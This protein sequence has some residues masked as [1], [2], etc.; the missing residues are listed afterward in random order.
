MC[1]TLRRTGAV[2]LCSILSLFCLTFVTHNASAQSVACNDNVQ[3]SLDENCQ[4]DIT[5]D[6]I[7]EGNSPIDPADYTVTISGVMGTTITTP[8]SYSVTVTL[9]ATGNNCWG[10][11]V[12]EDK[13]APQMDPT[14][15]V[16]CACPPGNTDPAC[17]FLCTDLDGILNGTVA[18]PAPAPVENCTTVTSVSNDVV[19]DGAMCGEQIITRTTVYTD[20]AGNTSD[21]CIQEFRLVTIDVTTDITAPATPVQLEC[22]ASASMQSI[23]DYFEPTLGT[24]GAAAQAWPTINGSPITGQLCNIVVTKVD[25]TF[26]VCGPNCSGNYKVI[27]NWTVL[28]W[29]SGATENFVQII[30]AD[31]T[32]G[33]TVDAEDIQVTVDPWGCVGN[34]LMPAPTLLHD[35]C[36]DVVTYTVSGPVGVSINLDPV[37][38][39]YYVY[40]APKGDHT[41]TYVASDCCG[42][43]TN[44][45]ITVSVV[46]KTAP[47]AIG[48]QNL[49]VSL[50][51][52]TTSGS[53]FAKIFAASVDNGSFDGCGPVHLEV[54][55]ETDACN[56][57][58]NITYNNDGHSFDS[59][60]DTDDGAFVRFC[61]ADLTDIDENGT[62]FGTVKVWLRVWD[63]GDMD[64]TFGSA[65][66]NYNETWIDVRVEDK[67]APAIL[68]PADITVECDADVNN[69]SVLGSATAFNTC[70]NPEV[71]YTDT[72]DLDGCGAGTIVRRWYVKSF[73]NIFC[74]QT[75][76]I[77]ALDPFNG[78]ITWPSD[79]DVVCTDLPGAPTAPIYVGGVCDQIA[80][81]VESDTFLLED[82]ACFKILN[83][84]TVIDWC[85]FDPNAS[86]PT[87]VWSHV[88]VVKVSDDVAPE[89][90]NCGPLMFEVDSPISGGS[91]SNSTSCSA[92]SVTLTNAAAD[93]GDCASAWLKWDIS[94]DEWGDGTIDYV[95]SSNLP[96]NNPFY[97]AP[98]TTNQ[99]VAVTLPNPI[100][101]SMNTHKVT[102]SVSDGCG[103][104]G[105]C[106]STFMVV[107]KK[108]PTPYCINLSTAL[109]QNGMVELWACDFDLG[110]FDNCTDIDDLRFTFTNTP[111]ESD[112]AYDPSTKCSSI[113][114]DCDDLP[115]DPT[116]RIE[117]E[118][119]VWDEKGN[120]DFCTVLVTLIDNQGGCTGAAPRAMISG[121]VE[122]PTGDVIEDASVQ[123]ETDLPWYPI[124]E[125]TDA[126]GEYAFD[127]NPMYIDYTIG[128]AKD[129]DDMN[130]VSTLD[131]V[132]IQK[133]ILGI[134]TLDNAY[135]VIA[136]DINSDEN[137]SAID[138]IELRKLILGIH[139]E[140]PNNTSWR[141]VDGDYTFADASD[142]F[143]FDEEIYLSQITSDMMSEKLIGIKVGDVNNTA[144]ANAQS[145]AVSNRSNTTLT[146]FTNDQEVVAGEEVEVVIS[147]ENFDNIIGFQYTLDV[148]GIE[149]NGVSSGTL[150]IRNHNLG[151]ISST[152]LTSSW[153]EV[154]GVTVSPEEALFTINFTARTS[155][156][157]SEMMTLTSSAT[158][159]EAYNAD[160]ETAD[161]V[162]NFRD[163]NGNDKA[164]F[165]L[166]QNSPNPFQNQT[167]ISFNVP[168]SG[169]ATL[170]VF[171]VTGKVV[172][173]NVMQVTKGYNE[174]QLSKNDL[175][176]Q[177]VMY[178]QLESGTN[179]ATRKMIE[180]E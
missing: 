114:F 127:S 160:L 111:P 57:A 75:I 90:L 8:G 149:L 4:A 13:L 99:E 94:V 64:G 107:D 165:Q 140:L 6:I 10:D 103:N 15:P 22:G 21:A 156:L 117:V 87:G 136:A 11:I 32:E 51:N 101:G 35:N 24:A 40:G 18:V 53:G 154:D 86:V 67:L 171:D 169:N 172:Y 138:L 134:T 110:S 65:G 42:N 37:T 80:Y 66:D 135:K 69:L 95:Y 27:R 68:C 139:S 23:F 153:N 7:L 50:T 70:G 3:V 170:S 81:S 131:L 45:D 12:V 158:Q 124:A 122:T 83:D 47:I 159:A 176:A 92:T 106:N 157:L 137:V 5:P 96:S 46:D 30:K 88:Q 9:N 20:A 147:A 43:T 54:R 177:G 19:T 129:N 28:D 162:L 145:V 97:V 16:Q 113:T 179:V 76:T 33:P 168:T 59:S 143:P 38:G 148:E 116:D 105:S 41:F 146:F 62:P 74:L 71:L 85:Q 79:Q 164:D 123:L 29:C 73:P 26:D 102:W 2:Y 48:T 126:N 39:Q 161:L 109:M 60:T 155:G 98:T 89:V 72:P 100:E 150:D 78:D 91:A 128:G 151:S 93:F 52:G 121:V 108:A 142:P 144:S 36:A 14:D 119:Y 25:Q 115:S 77:E 17:E 120:F 61:C 56:I 34:F 104:V 55:R 152:Q 82:G 178:Y 180:I 173:R 167:T 174:I 63:D 118:V 49:V 163:A 132:L 166:Y 58:G 112:P 130:G 1:K 31:D 141:F 175:N 44:F 84:Y 125:M 133:H